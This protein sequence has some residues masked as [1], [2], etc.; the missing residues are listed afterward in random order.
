VAVI[1]IEPAATAVTR[2]D[3]ETVATAGTLLDQEIARPVRTFPDASRAVA[4]SCI[5]RPTYR[6]AEDGD[7]L[8]DATGGVRMVMTAVSASS[9]RRAMTE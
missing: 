1:V 8:T 7:T 5:V 3:A 6:L 2:P 9:L 4:V